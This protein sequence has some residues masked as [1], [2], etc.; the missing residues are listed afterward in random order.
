MVR[1]DKRATAF[2]VWAIGFAL[3]A[4]PLAASMCGGEPSDEKAMECCKDMVHCNTPA[5]ADACCNP[6]GHNQTGDASAAVAVSAKQKSQ[7]DSAVLSSQPSV[8]AS[9]AHLSGMTLRSEPSLTPPRHPLITPLR[10]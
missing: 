3:V 2:A 1:L 9:V 8:S 10:I 5:K 7:T 6:E 4:S